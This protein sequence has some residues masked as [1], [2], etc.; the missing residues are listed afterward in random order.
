MIDIRVWI[1][2]RGRM[3]D[4]EDEEED[5]YLCYV[6]EFELNGKYVTA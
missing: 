2:E 5:L 3:L 4:A 6:K 1:S